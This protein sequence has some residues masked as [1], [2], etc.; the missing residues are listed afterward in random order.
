LDDTI[1]SS[2]WFE[3][4]KIESATPQNDDELYYITGGNVP[5]RKMETC[6]GC[7]K[8]IVAEVLACPYCGADTG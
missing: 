1:S 7:N 6:S 4:D 2:G 3:E 8:L 5:F